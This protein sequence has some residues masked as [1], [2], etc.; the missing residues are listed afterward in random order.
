MKTK[1]V[2]PKEP[3]ASSTSK[4]VSS[5]ASAS[6][7]P[8]SGC[9]S[10]SLE[11]VV[12]LRAQL[13]VMEEKVR[14]RE[15]LLLQAGVDLSSLREKERR[16]ESFRRKG[17]RCLKQR[18]DDEE[19]SRLV[20]KLSAD[21][22]AF[23][24]LSEQMH[25]G[26]LRQ[27]CARLLTERN[28][29]C[30]PLATLVA[31]AL[32]DMTGGDSA[33]EEDLKPRRALP[34]RVAA[35]L[36][37]ARGVVQEPAERGVPGG[38]S[39]SQ[40]VGRVLRGKVG[41][42]QQIPSSVLEKQDRMEGEKLSLGRG[43][44]EETDELSEQNQRGNLSLGLEREAAE[45]FWV[46][47]LLLQREEMQRKQKESASLRERLQAAE[48]VIRLTGAG[49]RNGGWETETAEA[50][51]MSFASQMAVQQ[52]VIERL[53]RELAIAE[54]QSQGELGREHCREL[55]LKEEKGDG[56]EEEKENGGK[57]ESSGRDML[58]AVS[59][60]AQAGGSL[61]G[62]SVQRGVRQPE[63]REYEDLLTAWEE[64]HR[65]DGGT[66]E[67]DKYSYTKCITE[68][69]RLL[70]WAGSEIDSTSD[71]FMYSME[72]MMTNRCNRLSWKILAE[73]QIRCLSDVLRDSLEETAR[74]NAGL[75]AASE[76]ISSFEKELE[77]VRALGRVVQ[78]TE[79]SPWDH[80]EG[81]IGKCRGEEEESL[82]VST[83]AHINRQARRLRTSTLKARSA[84]HKWSLVPPLL[85]IV[86]LSGSIGRTL[87]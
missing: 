68:M 30:D 77:R 85:G 86:T 71:R 31:S 63:Q 29:V 64:V 58:P 78:R 11:E 42:A 8:A 51:A 65:G 70:R 38:V 9:T 59:S 3:L 82:R 81:P 54:Q 35:A 47:V 16:A 7:S 66:E 83:N 84:L 61:A 25:S 45:V 40:S 67:G 28:A 80:F 49:G 23:G 34:E 44:E 43:E 55:K 72:K 69:R 18:L 60:H 36:S 52:A 39:A 74:L 76:A 24:I 17:G 75:C 33:E 1:K 4:L 14:V 26:L 79:H 15:D 48:A 41:D 57:I 22:R 37:F 5:S 53:S 73:L 19:L 46:G 87:D 56:A 10:S 6:K 27:L 13:E 32:G 2:P 50:A 12:G 62:E 20:E 21:P